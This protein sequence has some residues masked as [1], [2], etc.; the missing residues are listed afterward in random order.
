ME[1][2]RNLAEEGL[3]KDAIPNILCDKTSPQLQKLQEDFQKDFLKSDF[4]K[5]QI[6]KQGDL[7]NIQKDVKKS[8]LGERNQPR[9]LTEYLHYKLEI[10]DTLPEREAM[11]DFVERLLK[12]P[13]LHHNNTEHR[14]KSTD[15]N[16]ESVAQAVKKLQEKKFTL[17]LFV[18]VFL[19]EEGSCCFK[20]VRDIVEKVGGLEEMK[21]K[22]RSRAEHTRELCNKYLDLAFK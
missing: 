22:T 5:K 7:K 9:G 17:D 4:W 1:N 20:Q 11:K 6:K 19:A 21:K 18:K 10:S 3:S 15:V 14:E 13:Y 16:A 12:D 8:P 2:V